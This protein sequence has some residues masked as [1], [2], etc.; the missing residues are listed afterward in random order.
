M[1]KRI[2]D[3]NAVPINVVIIGLDSVLRGA[4]DRARPVLE[5]ELPGL[6]LKFHAAVDWD[7]SEKALASCRADIVTGDII[8]VAMLFVENQIQAVMPD[9]LARREN[10][11][12]MIACM[13]AAEIVKLTRLGR[14]DMQAKPSAAINLLKKL[15][16][17]GGQKDR[18]CNQPI[19]CKSQR[20][21]SVV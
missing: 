12:A 21:E 19:P 4:M 10:C 8:L 13:S 6:N 15:K 14:F 16:G 2:S 9:L 5:Q 11:D 17:S 3:D 1:Q 18:K 20:S 7:K